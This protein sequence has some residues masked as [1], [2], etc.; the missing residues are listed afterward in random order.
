MKYSQTEASKSTE[1]D[2]IDVSEVETLPKK[3][4]IVKIIF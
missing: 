3:I 4:L 1:Q 2:D